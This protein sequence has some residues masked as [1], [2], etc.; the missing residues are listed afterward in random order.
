MTESCYPPLETIYTFKRGKGFFST[1]LTSKNLALAWFS[2]M[3]RITY[4]VQLFECSRFPGEKIHAREQ[5]RPK[6]E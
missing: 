4:Q 5:I 3:Q 2:A 1:E 6:S